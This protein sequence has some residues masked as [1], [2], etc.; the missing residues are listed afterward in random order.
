MFR[1]LL[2]FIPIFAFPTAIKVGKNQHYKTIKSAIEAAQPG[3]SIMVEAGVYR[4]GNIN[5]AKPLSLIGIGRPVLDGEMKYEILSLRANH[6]VVK[7]FKL[8]NSGEDVVTNIGAMRLYDSQ[9]SKIVNNI[10][11][12]NYFGIYIQRGY[13]CLIQNNKITSNRAK[14][15]ESS[16]DGIHAWQS[17]ELWIKHNYCEG[18][19][20]GIY[21]EKVINSFVYKNYSKKNLRYG[22]H[23][24]FA[25]DNTYVGNT[26]DNND[27][28]VAVMYSNN[29]DMENNR[30]INNWGDGSY[31][32]L[33]KDIGFS[34]IKKNSFEN[35]T[36]AVFLDGATKIDFYTNQF[37][38]NGWGLKISA[39]SMENRIK[40]NNFINNIFDVSTNGGTVMNDFSGNYWDKNETYDLDKD[41]IADVPYHPLSL[42][43][44]LSERNPSVMV[45]FKSFFVDLLDRIEKV[46]PSLT[47]ENFVDDKP[48]M[49]PAKV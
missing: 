20:D 12:N 6:I 33:L 47:P 9:Y 36:T 7:G 21:M 3:D 38:N 42:Y 2:L 5:I 30:F 15:Q 17:E 26:F 43:S 23:F 13:R 8:I 24:M 49:K 31:G 39:N 4:E 45:L 14:S 11:E 32:L 41:K 19:K 40:N 16:G 28:G 25:N 48:L 46:I 22:L 35:N 27:A 10:F 44:V 29:V 18:N 34:K 37:S 1:F